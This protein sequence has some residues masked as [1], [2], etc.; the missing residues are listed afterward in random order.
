MPDLWTS[1][2]WLG[3]LMVPVTLL[4]RW[5][6]IHLHALG[7]ITLGSDYRAIWLRFLVLAPGIFLHE[8]S[9][10]ITARLLFVPTGKFSLGPSRSVTR[11]KQVQVTMGY[12]MIGQTDPIRASL[13]GV[14]PFI[15][16]TAAIVLIGN[17]GFR[18]ALAV[19]LPPTG[20]I[21]AVITHLTDLFRVPDA[22]LWLYL[23]FSISNSLIPSAS[24]RRDWW[25]AGLYL[26]ALAAIVVILTGVRQPPPELLAAIHRALDTL[27]F[28]FTLTLVIDLVM[29]VVIYALHKLISRLTGRRVYFR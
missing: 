18:Q 6:M 27:V 20:I 13:I 10:W 15:F 16:G 3:L 11:G 28:A 5:V 23:T 12:V 2:L 21:A 4:K 22:W 1:L 24:D 17:Y 26:I 29:G 19:D 14:A 25:A 9:H 7:V 8:F